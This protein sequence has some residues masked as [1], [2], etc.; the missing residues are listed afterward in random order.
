MTAL[1]IFTLGTPYGGW[2]PTAAALKGCTASAIDPGRAAFS[3]W[4]DEVV[5]AEPAPPRFDCAVSET[6]R[7]ALAAL[8]PAGAAWGGLDVRAC[9]TVD[10]LAMAYPAAHF[11][12]F[13]ETPA[14][15]LAAWLE[16]GGAGDPTVA[17]QRWR[18]GARRLLHHAHRHPARCL[19]VDAAEA[20][21]RV[22]ALAALCGERFGWPVQGVAPAPSAPDPLRAALGAALAGTDRAAQS[23]HAELHAA[24]QPLGGEADGLLDAS[25]GFEPAL[26]VRRWH[27]IQRAAARSSDENTTLQREREAMRGENELL[28]VQLHQVQEELEHYYLQ[29][30]K[31][32]TGSR[33]APLPALAPSGLRVE[34]TT[35][36]DTAPH[37]ELGFVLQRPTADAGPARVELRLVEHRGHPGL[38]VFQ[39]DGPRQLL[40]VWQE[41]GREGDRAYQLLIPADAAS[42]P[43]WRRMPGADWLTV[44]QLL[45]GIDAALEVAD[46]ARATRWR[47]VTA[48]MRA[49]LAEMP[50]RLRYDSLTARAAGEGAPA[51]E[52]CF[53]RVLFGARRF[54]G[55]TLLWRPGTAQPLDLLAPPP[56]EPPPLA[57]WPLDEA[58][59][60][61]P[62]WPL[63]LGRALDGAEARR[64]WAALSPVDRDLLLGL[65]DAL[66]AA[67]ERL[68]ES[69]LP[70]GFDRAALTRAAGRLLQDA[71]Q[72]L[73]PTRRQRLVRL[74]RGRA[75]A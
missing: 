19:L 30:Q 51:L 32:E 9:W 67:A 49:Q 70:A 40:S 6:Q 64:R 42:A 53:G 13:I 41:D 39:V 10:A 4:H 7:A 27:D 17:L 63:P 38:V 37:R 24:C 57:A 65:L 52:V 45:D 46:P 56:T 11:L 48:H 44:Q 59:Q 5:G 34:I 14:A 23:L 61:A 8:A 75:G 43:H 22:D 68:A 15:A 71:Q 66:P 18:A 33:A 50:A 26:A 55:L 25:A 35:E 60:R 54:G 20:A 28:L 58:G 31:L 12:I 36:R 29:Y 1:T 62:H 47:G 72:A 73:R 3:A 21:T 69:D 2:L 16:S 74:L